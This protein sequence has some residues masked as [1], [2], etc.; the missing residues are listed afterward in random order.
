MSFT[1]E[2]KSDLQERW[3]PFPIRS[4][5]PHF[6]MV[7]CGGTVPHQVHGKSPLQKIGSIFLSWAERTFDG[8]LISAKERNGLGVLCREEGDDCVHAAIIP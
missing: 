4:T 7:V 8:A 2:I 6:H 5:M 1:E 3:S